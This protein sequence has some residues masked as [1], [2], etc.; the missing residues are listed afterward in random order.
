MNRDLFNEAMNQID[1]RYLACCLD[2]QPQTAKKHPDCLSGLPTRFSLRKQLRKYAPALIGTVAC[3]CLATAVILV[4]QRQGQQEPSWPTKI[5]Q[6]QEGDILDEI[7]KVPHWD[8]MEIYEQYS[9][10]ECF[11]R[12]YNVQNGVIKPEQLGNELGTFTAQ[13]QDEYASLAGEDAIRFHP[14]T[15]YEIT[16]IS[17]DCAI[18][19]RYDG[20]DTY[21]AAVNSGYRPETLSDFLSDL[22]LKDTLQFNFVDYEYFKKSGEYCTVRFENVENSKIWELLLSNVQAKNESG[23]FG[24]DGTTLLSLS[25]SI[26]LLG[27]ENISITLHEDGYIFTN[28]LDTEKKFYIGEENAQAFFRYVLDECEGYELIFEYPQAKDATESNPTATLTP[29]AHPMHN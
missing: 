24:S 12:L 23:D 8:E 17:P 26:P 25:V 6:L 9:N 5:I 18:A 14:A 20:K 16:G 7:Y 29:I 2:G 13:G 1:E 10:I 11:G 15:A 19:I 28:I 4:K 3:A 22:N 21:Y 27:C